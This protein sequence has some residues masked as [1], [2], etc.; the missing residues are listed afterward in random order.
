MLCTPAASAVVRSGPTALLFPGAFQGKF[1]EG[2]RLCWAQGPSAGGA[3]VSVLA[4]ASDSPGD[5]HTLGKGH[6]DLHGRNG[7]TSLSPPCK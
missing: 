5:K 3:G 6:S 2:S 4:K 1:W 7:K